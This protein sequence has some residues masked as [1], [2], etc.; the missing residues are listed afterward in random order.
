M[1]PGK[2][3]YL[4]WIVFNVNLHGKMIF[5]VDLAFYTIRISVF[6]INKNKSEKK[7]KTKQNKKKQNFG[8]FI[9]NTIFFFNYI[10]I[11]I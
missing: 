6:Q 3:S 7:S 8:Y 1:F 5:R 9:L 10:F 2:G 4:E 11:K